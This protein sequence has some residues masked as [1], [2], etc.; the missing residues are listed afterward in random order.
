[1]MHVHSAS[2]SEPSLGKSTGFALIITLIMVVLAA[3]IVIVFL[4]SASLDRTT[5]KSVGDRYQAELAVQNGLEAAKKTLIASPTAATSLTKDDTFLVVRVDAPAVPVTPAAPVTTASYYYLAKAQAG[6]AN[7]IDYYP[8]FAGGTVTPG[9]TINLA[10]GAAQPAVTRPTP[11]PNPNPSSAGTAAVDIDS[12]KTKIIKAYPVVSSWLGPPSTQWQ[13]IRDPNDAATAPSH[14][15][16][17]QRYTFWIEDLSGYLDASVVGNEDNSG[18]HQRTNGTNPK[19]IALFTIFQ[20][21]QPTDTGK[22]TDS[23]KP[24]DKSL[25]DGR[26]LLFTVPTLKQV[27][28]P[29]PADVTQPNLAVRLGVDTGGEQN[30]VPFG[31]EYPASVEGK[32]KA[33]LKTLINSKD[34]LGIAGAITTALPNFKNRAGGLPSATFDYVK[35]LAAN[36]V[37]YVDPNNAPT[38]DSATSPT[39]RGIGAFPFL[40]SAYDLNNWVSYTQSGG[41]YSV[42]I[43]VTT[44][45]QLWNPHN[46]TVNANADDIVIHYENVDALNVNGSTVNYSAPPN[47]INNSTTVPPD[48]KISI[49]PN[50]YKVL[51]FPIKTYT[52]DWGPTQPASN[53]NIPFPKDTTA[54][55]FQLT[56]K[57][58]IADRTYKNVQRPSASTGMKYNGPPNKPIT[59]KWEWRGNAAPPIYPSLG[60]PGDARISFYLNRSWTAANYEDN[61]SWGGRLWLKGITPVVEMQPSTWPDGGHNS[62]LGN[63]PSH[64]VR[65][66]TSAGKVTLTA[67]DANMWV[68]RLSTRAPPALDTL[69]ELG[70][71]FDPSQWKYSIPSNYPLSPPTATP[72]P[73][74]PTSATA[75]ST[76]GGGYTLCVG[77]PEFSNFD[78]NHLQNGVSVGGN[79]QRAW[80]LLDMFSLGP[81]R[82][83][84]TGLI[85]LNTASFEALRALA[86]GILHN[87]DAAIQPA[88]LYPPKANTPTALEQQP[89]LRTSGGEAD[90]FAEAVIQ[91]RP[92]L[93]TAQI[94]TIKNNLGPFFGNANQWKDQTVP[95]EWNDSAREELFSKL[96]NLA[97]VRSRNFRVF[98]TGQALDKNGKVLSTVNKVF[99]VFLKP[100]RAADGSI[101]SQQ[102]EIKYEAFL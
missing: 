54:N 72:A 43:E 89:P 2:T 87:R 67:A 91:S 46:V 11:P 82:T 95:S 97:T 60:T 35:N 17:Y 40:V 85:N 101:N 77:R 22:P 1:M 98:V 96:L 50:G 38:T 48:G 4:S 83:I 41:E 37:D 73:D 36:I 20:P 12:A 13:E 45:V 55:S 78:T 94:Q 23:P 9:L 39:Y 62:T 86:G 3:I 27:A 33:D 26:A 49:P 15:L 75:D 24:L 5:S 99:Q 58:K 74:V 19:E 66:D 52:F 59:S 16:P 34:V 53:A 51:V 100:A 44:Y 92:L 18:L 63:N 93:S 21:T 90:L 69:A 31:Y 84:T 10:A 79:G 28:S 61:S 68:S 64:S 70:N 7:K 81:A 42:N 56:W 57:G 32:P 25:I 6:S 76:A 29:A 88:T 102:T 80:Q 71:V 47:F 65:P 8:L 14:S 30:L